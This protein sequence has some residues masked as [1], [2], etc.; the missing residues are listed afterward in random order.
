MMFSPVDSRTICVIVFCTDGFTAF[1]LAVFKNLVQAGF[2]CPN[3]P[4]VCF[5]FMDLAVPW[6]SALVLPY[7]TLAVLITLSCYFVT[8]FL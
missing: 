5:H 8:F 7:I 2:S 3:Y 4:I 6:S 1:L